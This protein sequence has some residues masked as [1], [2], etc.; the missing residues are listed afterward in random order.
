MD[1][2]IFAAVTVVAWVGLCALLGCFNCSGYGRDLS[3]VMRGK[4]F[5]AKLC[6]FL[7]D[8]RVVDLIEQAQ[9]AFVAEDADAL[10]ANEV[11]DGKATANEG[12]VVLLADAS[13]IGVANHD[14][15]TGIDNHGF[16]LGKVSISLDA[17]VFNKKVFGGIVDVCTKGIDKGG[18]DRASRDGD[19]GEAVFG[20]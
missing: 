18:A 15:G 2:R 3:T 20:T 12:D 14:V 6:F 4:G 13:A 7:K 1:T 10:P 11:V 19:S 17:V 5:L 16:D 8:E 9:G